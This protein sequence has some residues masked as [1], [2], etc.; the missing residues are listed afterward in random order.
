MSTA[1]VQQFC[2]IAKEA[3]MDNSFGAKLAGMGAGGKFPSNIER[4]LSR[5]MDT[6]FGCNCHVFQCK[7][8]VRDIKSVC[9][10]VDVGMLLPHEIAHWIWRIAPDAFAE[11]FSVDRLEEFWRRTIIQNE[12]WFQNHPM[13][14]RIVGASDRSKFLAIHFFGDDGTLRKSR[15][16]K[17]MTFFSAL[18]TRLSALHSRIPCYVLPRHIC[19]DDI[20]ESRLQECL[21]WSMEMW[22]T[23]RFPNFGPSGEDWAAGSLQSKLAGEQICGGYIGVYCGTV[24][25]ALWIDQHYRYEQSWSKVDICTRCCAQNAAGPTNFNR[26]IAFPRRSHDDYMRSGGAA[27]SPLSRMPG[28]WF[29]MTRPEPM[30]VGPLGALPEAV[31]SALIELCEEDAFGF[32]DVTPWQD[33][34]N[35]QL[36]EASRQF[37]LWGKRCNCE[38]T[39]KCFTRCGMSMYTLT[40]SF[41][42]YKGKAH[43]CLV[44]TRWLESRCSQVAHVSEYSRLRAA[45]LFGWVDFFEVCG[46]TED[47]DWLNPAELDRFDKSAQLIVHGMSSLARRNCEAGIPKWKTLPKLHQ[48]YHIN[49]DAQKSHRPPRA[50]WSFKDEE[51]MGCLSK[52]ACAVHAVK[53]SSRS[54]QRWMMQFF[55]EIIDA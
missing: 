34:L 54:L 19:L 25:D 36:R 15:V 41:P 40:L 4:D 35:A 9:K 16:M 5:Y 1:D 8:F 11:L 53:I 51:M 20:T 26:S 30:H 14:E 45:V 46:H 28:F 50:F 48:I 17:T 3:G 22:L 32:G 13:R 23:G 10:E 24:A 55:S 52:I 31:G 6:V 39:V 12:E 47:K 44:I 18:G 29:T 38:H 37:L 42:H 43:N 2:A 7:A 21:V 49:E 33:R 27:Q